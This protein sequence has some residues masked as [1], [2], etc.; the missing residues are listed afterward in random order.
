[1]QRWFLDNIRGDGALIYALTWVNDAHRILTAMER[2]FQLRNIVDDRGQLVNYRTLTTGSLACRDMDELLHFIGR[3]I[4]G[5]QLRRFYITLFPEGVDD[6]SIPPESK[7][8]LAYD[9][10][11]G[12]DAEIMSTVFPTGDI[13][14]KK[15]MSETSLRTL[16]IEP[17]VYKNRKFGL[18]FFDFSDKI[19]IYIFFMIRIILPN[20]LNAL[21]FVSQME[22]SYADLRIKNLEIVRLSLAVEHS[23]SL[24][25][26]TD[27]EGRIEYANPKFLEFHGCTLERIKGQKTSLLN[28]GDTPDEIYM[29]LWRT[30]R[31]GNEWR[32]ELFNRKA[33][34]ETYW[35]L[36]AISPVTD[37]D[38]K[39]TN[40]VSIQ[41]NITAFK[42]KE[43]MLLLQK[44]DLTQLAKY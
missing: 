3:Q 9:L 10:D 19:S 22:K 27:T 8:V 32:G 20:A 30:V 36:T 6:A 17:L 2:Q 21:I 1:M 24:I 33:N 13:L 38:G 4:S 41:E 44:Q 16:I 7:L 23:A 43:E 39:I 18:A 15:I 26:I 35:A 14:P 42:A 37:Q 25:V 11:K 5:F 34:G 12:P 28:T 40:F 29:D 31:S